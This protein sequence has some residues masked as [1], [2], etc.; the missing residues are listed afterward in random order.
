MNKTQ[1]YGLKTRKSVAKLF[2]IV[3]ISKI[4]SLISGIKSSGSK[5]IFKIS[6]LKN[7]EN[8]TGKHLCWSL[9]LIKLQAFR[10]YYSKTPT[11]VF[12]CKISKIFKNTFFSQNSSH[13][14]FCS[15]IHFFIAR[16]FCKYH[17]FR[18]CKDKTNNH[19][20]IYLRFD[21]L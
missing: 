2:A 12:S 7:F 5:M 6:A 10:L 14:W 20:K 1:D 11:Q 8:F 21:L 15:I 19:S 4:L 9:F 18:S 17:F 13:S 16:K 3:V